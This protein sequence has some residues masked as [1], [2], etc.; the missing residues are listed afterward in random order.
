VLGAGLRVLEV[1]AG[2]C[3]LPSLVLSSTHAGA[4]VVATDANEVAALLK[5]NVET[6]AAGKEGR[7]LSC[8]LWW[9]SEKSLRRMQCGLSSDVWGTPDD[10]IRTGSDA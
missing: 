10:E 9:G 7:L 8:D 1:G 4:E 3:G 6:Q 2:A 5:C